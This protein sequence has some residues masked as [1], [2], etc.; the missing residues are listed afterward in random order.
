MEII[1]IRFKGE[2][3]EKRLS[4]LYP[5]SFEFE[6]EGIIY[7]SMEAFFGTLRTP[8]LFD[9]QKLYNTS[10]MES[11][12]LGHKF[13]WY[14]KQEVYYKDKV[15]SRHSVEYD[16][17]IT[18]AFD[19]LFTNE[20]FKEALRESGDCK[21]THTIGKTAKDKTLLT[22]KEF[23]GH[24]NRLRNKLYERKFYDLSQLFV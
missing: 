10:G 21:L 19:A 9:K 18:A 4:N 6:F 7:S 5:Y 13:T 20:D 24:L 23:T 12:Y 8:S 11:W 17:L 15:I 14:E 1:N 22:R 16:E 2:N 3:L